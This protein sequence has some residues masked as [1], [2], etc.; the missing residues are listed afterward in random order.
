ML[1]AVLKRGLMVA[2]GLKEL[3]KCN[4]GDRI[5][6]GTIAGLATTIGVGMAENVV[7]VLAA[8]TAGFSAIECI[9]VLSGTVRI[10]G[11]GFGLLGTV[12][13]ELGIDDVTA[14]STLQVMEVLAGLLE[15]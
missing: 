12:F 15:E 1:E 3:Q 10:K 5:P 4:S 2:S 11:L 14:V 13:V 7:M 8:V 6:I 9:A